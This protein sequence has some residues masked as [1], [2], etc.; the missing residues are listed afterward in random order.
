MTRLPEEL[1]RS[2]SVVEAGERM[3]ENGFHHLPIMDGPRLYGVL[4]AR[5]VDVLTT[6]LGDASGMP[7]GDVCITDPYTVSPTAAV[8]DVARTMLERHIGSAVV[9]DG[10]VVVGIFTVTDALRALVDAYGG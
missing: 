4:S 8:K 9:V 2:A 5:D 6:A 7:V 3:R 1:D 10:G